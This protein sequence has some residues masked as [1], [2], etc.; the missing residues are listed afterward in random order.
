MGDGFS[1]QRGGYGGSTR[2]VA[3]S[4]SPRTG[5]QGV[6]IQDVANVGAAGK[7][8]IPTVTRGAMPRPRIAAAPAISSADLMSMFVGAPLATAGK[9]YSGFPTESQRQQAIIGQ[10]SAVSALEELARAQAAQDEAALLESF[11]ERI[12]YGSPEVRATQARISDVLSRP[13]GGMTAVEE[14]AAAQARYAPGRGRLAEIESRLGKPAFQ[15]PASERETLQAEARQ[16]RNLLPAEQP[17]ETARVSASDQARQDAYARAIERRNAVAFAA[18]TRN[19][20]GNVIQPS[21]ETVAQQQL[22]ASL[23]PELEEQYAARVAPSAQLANELQNLP[24]AELAQLIATQQFG[25]DEALAA[26]LFGGDF[27]RQQREREMAERNIFPNQSIEDIIWST[28]GEEALLQYQQDRADAALAKLDEGFRT[29]DEAAIDLSI[30]QST[31][32]PVD[33]AAGDYDRARARGYLVDPNFMAYLDQARTQVMADPATS[34]EEKK[35]LMRLQAQDFYAQTGDPVGAEILLN[36]LLSFDFT[37][38]F[39]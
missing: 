6:T 4:T 22:R 25:M 18:P 19:L 28:Q 31:G 7:S 16:L 36:A 34:V 17:I 24:R 23:A 37:L 11:G 13:I 32:I 5:P 8:A 20:A 33:A 39:E 3:V 2:K 1:S 15:V 29:E 26:G 12:K 27:E 35:N 9:K 38:A 14:L 21:W 30:E 10:L